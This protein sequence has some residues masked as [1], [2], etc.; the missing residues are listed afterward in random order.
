MTT[1]TALLF[2]TGD[3]VELKVD[4]QIHSGLVLLVNEI[5]AIIDLCDDSVPLVLPA[6]DFAMVR[7]FRPLELAA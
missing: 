6:E 2:E 7:V 1:A 4:G 3:V 5:A